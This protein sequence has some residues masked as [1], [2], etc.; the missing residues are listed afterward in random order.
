MLLHIASLRPSDREAWQVLARGYKEFYATPTTDT[1]YDRAWNR[2]LAQ[3]GVYGLGAVTCKIC[4]LRPKRGVK[5]WLAHSSKSLQ[6]KH[7][8]MAPLATIG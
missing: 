5:A 1:E 3:D 8:L 4:L 2:L 6:P 7:R